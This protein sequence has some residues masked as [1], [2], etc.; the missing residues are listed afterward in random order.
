MSNGQST[1][2]SFCNLKKIKNLI[3]VLII[4]IKNP[5]SKLGESAVENRES[6]LFPQEKNEGKITSF[7]LVKDHLVYSTDVI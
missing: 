3:K 4:S 5:I 1:S 2:T 6:I 7:A